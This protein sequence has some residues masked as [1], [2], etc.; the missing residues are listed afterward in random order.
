MLCS[1]CANGA[2]EPALAADVIAWASRRIEV[3][4][5]LPEGFE[6]LVETLREDKIRPH[7]TVPIDSDGIEMLSKPINAW[8]NKYGR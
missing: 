4:G 5:Q 8:I 2:D 7:V 6:P 3:E 1:G